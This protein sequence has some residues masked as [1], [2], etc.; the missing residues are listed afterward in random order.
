MT[1]THP[2]AEQTF[3]QHHALEKLVVG[4]AALLG[5]GANAALALAVATFLYVLVTLL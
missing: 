3:G 5:I 4:I 2:Q 1:P